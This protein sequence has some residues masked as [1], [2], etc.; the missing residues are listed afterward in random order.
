MLFHLSSEDWLWVRPN[1][2]PVTWAPAMRDNIQQRIYYAILCIVFHQLVQDFLNS[3]FCV[4]WI[5]LLFFPSNLS[6]PFC[7]TM[8]TASTSIQGRIP[9]CNYTLSENCLLLIPFDD[10][11]VLYWKRYLRLPSSFYCSR[12][13]RS[14]TALPPSQLFSFSEWKILVSVWGMS[15]KTNLACLWN[16]LSLTLFQF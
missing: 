9:Q 6:R 11:L 1:P 14:N 3:S 2:L 8:W 5:C 4:W 13:Y 7:E 16:S 15:R 12:F 10:A